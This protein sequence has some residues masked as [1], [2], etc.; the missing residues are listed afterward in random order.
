MRLPD[1]SLGQLRD[2]ADVT[3]LIAS[4]HASGLFQALAPAP[5]SADDVAR[6]LDL[7]VR[8]TRITLLALAEA[9][10]L[11]HSGGTF[12]PSARCRRELC[13][14]AHP[15]YV[16][17][18]L[19]HWLE[20]I[21]AWSRLGDVLRRGG[22]LEGRKGAREPEG[23][24]RF[25]SAMAAAPR[26]R[27]E[28]IVDRCLDRLP[29]ARSVLDVGAGP[30]HVTRAF[31]AR[32]LRATLFDRPEIVDHVREAYDLAG[33]DGLSLVAGDFTTDPLPE[34]PFDVVLL[35]N[36]LHIY[37]PHRNRAL[38]GKAAEVLSPAGV[39]AV[40]EFL[41]GRS[42]KAARF[43]VQMLVKTEEGDAYS[44]E[45]VAGWLTDAGFGDVQVDDLDADRQLVTAAKG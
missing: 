40:A 44:E 16:G 42:S 19:P 23:V 2:L 13:D 45:Q 43:G 3:V 10:L 12:T 30:G 27:I 7:D 26:E 11:E 20:S 29:G 22:P 14:P 25:M 18:G 15:E 5:A 6:S 1:L 24:A 38:L 17:G 21:R 8:A 37:G 33:V 35:S 39:V 9:G 28:R 32:G 41:R 31:A 36:V 34:G 4:A